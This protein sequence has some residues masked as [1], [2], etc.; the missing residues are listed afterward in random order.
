MQVVHSVRGRRLLLLM[1][2]W[3]AVMGACCL[4]SA[5]TASS[6]SLSIDERSGLPTLARGGAAA[7]SADYVFWRENWAFADTRSQLKVLGPFVYS[8]AGRVEALDLDLAA[9]ISRAAERQLTWDLTFNVRT[10]TGRAI[11]GGISFKF[12]LADFADQLGEP[13]LLPGNLGWAWGRPGGT[14]I[15]MRFDRPLAA[16]YYERGKRDEIRAF[17]YKDAFPSGTREFR[18]TLRVSGD[19]V[20]AP[21]AGERFGLED[22]TSWPSG[23]LAPDIS[24]VDLS[25]LNATERPAGKHGALRVHGGKLQFDDGTFVRFWGTNLTAYALF[26]TPREEVRKQAHRM[27]ELGFNLVRLHHHDSEWVIPNIF[28]DQSVPDTR[29][30][31][32]HMLEK[33]DWW[34]KCL[35][36]EGI[37]V[38]LD[39]HVGRR[40]KAADGI[41]DFDEIRQGRPSAG[42]NGFNYVNDSIRDA[43]L[44]FDDSYLNHQNRFTGVR[45][46]DDAAIVVLLITNENDLTNHYGNALL[47]D[48]G[49]PGHSAIYMQDARRFAARYGLPTDKVW[50]AW[51]PGPSKLFLNDLE[52]RFGTDMIFHLHALGARVPVVTTSTWG[53]NPLSSLPALTVGDMIDVHSY[54]GVGELEKNPVFAANLVDWMAAAEVV[55]KPLSVSEW[56]VDDSGALAPDRQDI[57]LY[58]GSAAALH[59]WDAVMLYA[60]SQ[61]PPVPGHGS[62]SIYHAYNDPAL[63]ASM[64]AAALLYRQGHVHESSTRYVFAPSAQMLF[65]QAISA[66]NSVALRTAAERGRLAIALPQ[67]AELPWLEASALPP[68]AQVIRDPARSLIAPGASEIASDSGE[69]R[70]NWDR[71]T[72]TIDTPRT[73]AA[74][75][76]IGGRTFQFSKVTINVSTRNAVVAVQ[77]LD[78]EELGQARTVMISVGAR[79]V[80]AGAKALPYYSEPVEGSI[81]VAA[82]AGLA[83]YGWDARSAKDRPLPVAFQDGRYVVTLTRSLASRWLLLASH[84]PERAKREN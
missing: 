38:W 48:K 78:G 39:L 82:P 61:E 18:A 52:Q 81:V 8:V 83:L 56:G 32:E 50:R 12:D 41:R 14:Q 20:L 43:M 29:T 4:C 33:L 76:W 6:W 15:E 44:R 80:P 66:G 64:P 23:I 11:G 51:E 35:K 62:V 42:L 49:V 74:M 16:L 70:R 17:F 45:Y 73:Q 9:R 5:A 27:S 72:F 69:L 65:N 59:G 60:Y 21:T 71:G 25:F 55:G 31:N 68:D 19:V 1:I 54:G 34:I 77:S 7:L 84:T 2:M 40:V 28:G 22:Y 79:A 67:V 13:V 57:P 46:K 47:P 63:M 53:M 30:L 58:V 37:Y 36:D 26:A 3:L 75:G 24:P 10:G